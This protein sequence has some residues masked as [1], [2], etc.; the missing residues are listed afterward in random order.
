VSRKPWLVSSVTIPPPLMFVSIKG[1]ASH[2]ASIHS[3]FVWRQEKPF[4]FDNNVEKRF[5]L[6]STSKTKLAQ[7]VW[8]RLSCSGGGQ[9]VRHV[10]GR[11]RRRRRTQSRF[12]LNR[13]TT[14]TSGFN[15]IWF[16]FKMFT[17]FKSV[18]QKKVGLYLCKY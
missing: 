2:E 8:R 4:S 10:Q 1:K 18:M 13:W 14:K 5:H 12:P 9:R 11:F 7:H 15:F 17:C 6:T 3:M 16:I